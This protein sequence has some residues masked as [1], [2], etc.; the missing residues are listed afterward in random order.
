MTETEVAA[1]LA[2]IPPRTAKLATTRADGRPHVTPIWFDVDDDG[3]LVFNTGENTVKGRNLARQPWASLCVD[4]DHPPYSFVI[5]EGSVEISSDLREVR[6]LATR[7][8][9]RYMGP[10]RAREFGERNGVAG[11]L[12]V[13]LRL[14][15][16]VSALDMA[17]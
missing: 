9:R 17:D 3:S 16:V 12:A 11:E 13:R 6:R 5:V 10:D 14:G 7:I 15:R 1:F 2:S 4:D 8:G